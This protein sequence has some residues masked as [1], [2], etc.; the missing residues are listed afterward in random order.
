MHNLPPACEGCPM[1]AECQTDLAAL[2]AEQ[3]AETL[4]AFTAQDHA[5]VNEAFAEGVAEQAME[6]LDTLP[7]EFRAL[8]AV[9]VASAD[10]I[11]EMTRRDADVKR[12]K[13]TATDLAIKLTA[14]EYNEIAGICAQHGGGICKTEGD[15]RDYKPSMVRS[16]GRM[17]LF[18]KPAE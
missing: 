1:L 14:M 6:E 8:N 11:A 17:L 3:S 10:T 4:T 5:L 15:P 18:R 13:L 16:L 2:Y 12:H 7:S 9:A